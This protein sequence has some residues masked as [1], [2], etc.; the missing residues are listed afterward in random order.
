MRDYGAAGLRRPVLEQ[1][2]TDAAETFLWRCDD[3]PWARNVWNIHPEY[4]I[5]LIRNASGT[6]LVGDHIEP[7]EPG[8][9]AIVGSGLPHDWVTPT[10]PGE[11]IPG[12]D[13]VLQFDAERLRGTFALLP[14]LAG[15]GPFLTLALRGLAFQG[16]T[17]R[18][19]AALLEAM[20]DTA[21]I[22]RLALFLRLLSTLAGGDYKVLSSADFA[23]DTDDSSQGALHVAITHIR[24]NFTRELALSEVARL[25]GM[26]DWAFSRF[27]KK[28]SGS[29]F[30]DYVRTLRIGYACKLLTETQM[31][32]TDICFET[33]YANVSNFNRNFHSQRGTTPSSYRRLA[34]R[35]ITS[36]TPAQEPH[37]TLV[38]SGADGSSAAAAHNA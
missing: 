38:R 7:F 37:D 17:R 23:P 11:I 28:N 26:S 8:Y 1:I 20:R 36:R 13:I 14:E 6:A 5:H 32:I 21:G 22:E 29:S 25:V 15:I 12:R 31:P 10:A 33:G 2:V 24:E 27:F 16:E 30:T 35:R 9:L 34:Q 4:E 18:R 3:Y 19:G